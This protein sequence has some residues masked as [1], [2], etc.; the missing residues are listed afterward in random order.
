M[1]DIVLETIRAIVLL[2]ILIFLW[3]SGRNRFGQAQNG[4]NF[5]LL[6]FGL[7][8]FG[9]ILDISDNFESLNP[10]IVIGDTQTEAFLEKFVGFL[11]G[12]IF[13]AVGLFKWIPGVQ[14][15]SVLVDNRTHEI[16]ETNMSLKK[17]RETFKALADNIPV[18]ISLKD[19]EG[20]F[21]FV[22][23]CFEDWACVKSDD[24]VGKTVYDIYPEEQAAEF[25]A[26][27]A[28]VIDSQSVMS[29][30]IEL[31]YPDG[32]TRTVISTRFPVLSSMDDVIGL[33]TINFD[34]TE[35]K[36]AEKAKN[37]FISTVSHELRTPLTSIKGSIGLIRS[38]TAGD[39]P[40]KIRSMLDIAYNN[41]DRLVTLINDI[42]DIEK[43]EA[44]KMIFQMRQTDVVCLV[45]EAIKANKGY[46]DEYN[47]TFI[48]TGSP[49]ETL[50]EGDKDRLTQVLSNLMS[51]AA[52]FSPTG[53]QV[54]LSITRHDN[55][56][57][58]A[59][60]DNGPGIPEE[61]KGVII[62]KFTQS[63]SSD[64]R[65]TGGTGLG[66]SI[67]KA[68]VEQHGGTFG[69]NSELGVGSTFF[70]TLPVLE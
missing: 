37:E 17:S 40:E 31:A 13:L 27:D 22:N 62:E 44:N 29:R 24:I 26:R 25:A 8:F 6:G 60:K 69:Y 14:G 43:I 39:L 46:G 55:I 5:I 34:I 1:T 48:L 56:V 59:V 9:S 45:E 2:G 57:R 10:F 32:H 20:R 68:I 3:N 16:Q 18:F 42:L 7:L 28:E 51:N 65:Q 54:E 33:G 36:R 63:D 23:K 70:F 61:F 41:S 66:L 21:Q 67:A 64:T 50:V 58:I 38:G 30:E 52:K 35:H 15:L 11:G 4:W 53:E 19:T 47:V 12:F 49:E